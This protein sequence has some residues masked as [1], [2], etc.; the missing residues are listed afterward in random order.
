[1]GIWH[2]LKF[3]VRAM[4]LERAAELPREA[5]ERIQRKRLESHWCAHARAHSEFYREKYAGVDEAS[6]SSSPIC[7]R[8]TKRR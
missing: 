8:R 7:R 2:S 6:I 3:G 5:I 1:M 4:V